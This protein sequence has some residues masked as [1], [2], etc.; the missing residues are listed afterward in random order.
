MFQIDGLVFVAFWSCA[1]FMLFLMI[2]N[3]VPLRRHYGYDP[4]SGHSW[5][6]YARPS[7]PA[8][9][10]YLWFSVSP[11]IGLFVRQN[12]AIRGESN[13]WGWEYWWVGIIVLT[14]LG[15]LAWVGLILLSKKEKAENVDQVSNSWFGYKTLIPY[16]IAVGLGAS[17]ATIWHNDFTTA[18]IL[19]SIIVVSAFAFYILYRRTIKL[20]LQ[21]ILSMVGAFTIGIPLMITVWLV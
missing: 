20:K 12:N 8:L 7:T 14:V 13:F 15:I 5:Y 6:W 11:L 17:G 3:M 4:W 2:H 18:L 9:E 1:F 10:A 19:G 16:F 21:D